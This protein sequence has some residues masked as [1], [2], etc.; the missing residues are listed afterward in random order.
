MNDQPGKR[1]G[2]VGPLAEAS[3]RIRVTYRDT[4]QMGHVYYANYLVY[5]EIGRTELLR[6][7]GSTYRE[8]EEGGVF[9]PVREA[10]C[11]YH[12]AARYDDLVEIHT[13][14]ARWTRAAL[15]FEYE[16]RRLADGELLATGT[17]CHVFTDASGR[18]S[19]V[20][21]RIVPPSQPNASPDSA[22]DAA[23]SSDGT[24]GNDER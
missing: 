4:D 16:C 24:I 22:R 19:R 5:F 21:D 20:G 8:C 9:L 11:R 10:T 23:L 7:M 3:T 14:V 12:A 13:R 17:T 1:S 2:N 15:D 6:Q 18:V